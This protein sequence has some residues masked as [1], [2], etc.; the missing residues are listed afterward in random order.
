MTTEIPPNEPI[1]NFVLPIAK[2]GPGA[3][4]DELE[5]VELLGTCFLLSG[6]RG[7]AMT[8]KHVARGIT[9]GEAAV[10]FN[11]NGT[12]QL[13]AVQGIEEHPAEDVALLRLEPGDYPSPF[14]VSR[15]HVHAGC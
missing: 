7:L 2:V 3:A 9:V 1:A 10:M 8:A 5:Y 14:S 12:W 4:A 6:S 13:A 11:R 15:F